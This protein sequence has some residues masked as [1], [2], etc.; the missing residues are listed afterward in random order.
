[1]EPNLFRQPMRW[2]IFLLLLLCVF[3]DNAVREEVVGIRVLND[4]FC[5]FFIIIVVIHTLRVYSN[6]KMNIIHNYLKSSY[7]ETKESRRDRFQ[8]EIDD[9]ERERERE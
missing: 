1:M 3:C 4:S 7:Q 6:T 8:R 2:C 5:Y 9:W